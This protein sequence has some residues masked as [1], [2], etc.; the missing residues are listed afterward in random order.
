MSERKVG[1]L[2]RIRAF[3]FGEAFLWLL[4]LLAAAVSLTGGSNSE[5]A[6][7]LAGVAALAAIG[8]RVTRTPKSGVK[9]DA[10]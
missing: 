6:T 4:F 9:P 2:A 5:Q 8:V 3:H 1:L 7:T 10:H